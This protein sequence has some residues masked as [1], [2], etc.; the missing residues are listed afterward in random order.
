MAFLALGVIL[1]L[2]TYFLSFALEEEKISELEEKND[3]V[4]YLA[5]AGLREA[6]WKLSNDQEWKNN[7]ERDCDWSSETAT[8]E[9]TLFP[10]GSYQFQVEN[11]DCATGE[12]TATSTLILNDEEEIHKVLSVDV[13]RKLVTVNRS[14]AL[15]SGW[16]ESQNITVSDSVL[17]V[18]KGNIFSNNILDIK[19]GSYISVSDDPDTEELEGRALAAGNLIISDSTLEAEARCAANA[20]TEEC[21]GY[22]FGVPGCPPERTE[23]P[24]VDFNSIDNP[25]SLKN[26][27]Q[28]EENAGQCE[29]LCNGIPCSAKCVLSGS[30]FASLLAE[31]G[32]LGT[33]T[34]NNDITYIE[35]GVEVD[36][37]QELSVNGILAVDG[38][39][40]IWK[41]IFQRL[42]IKEPQP[43]A[44]AGL[45]TAGKVSLG[46]LSFL[47]QTNVTGIIYAEDE[48]RI[49]GQTNEFEVL[50]GILGKKITIEDVS[51]GF[52]VTLDN[53]KVSRAL[54]LSLP[55]GTVQPSA[56]YSSETKLA[57]WREI[58]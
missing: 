39:V 54:N 13:S 23:S 52:N 22:E 5:E 19:N 20:C 24:I 2:G 34:L 16:E 8:R 50:G 47:A 1:L 29:I 48:I 55:S 17:S 57:D 33:L 32:S 15:Y 4:Y 49:E 26:L 38:D 43:D 35:G 7:F 44:P 40:K 28:D 31:A 58:Y 18:S 12:I 25:N 56:E 30:E 9:N 21:E 42:I 6:L 45:L 27:A 14:S 10:D 41:G 51:R 37:W 53:E 36:L 3:Q 11:S 46:K